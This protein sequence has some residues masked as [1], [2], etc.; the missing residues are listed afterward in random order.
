MNSINSNS[1]F[2]KIPVLPVMARICPVVEDENASMEDL[3]EKAIDV[4]N[5]PQCGYK[6]PEWVET[7]DD[8]IKWLRETE[9]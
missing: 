1:D 6:I 7:S 3:I 5:N 9:K 4:T 2:E 8:F